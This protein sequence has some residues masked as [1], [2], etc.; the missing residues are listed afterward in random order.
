MLRL[1]PSRLAALA[2]TVPAVR[3]ASWLARR[4]LAHDSPC[5]IPVYDLT[6]AGGTYVPGRSTGTPTEGADAHAT[7]AAAVTLLAARSPRVVARLANSA[8]FVA[9]TVGSTSVAYDP[10]TRAV[11]LERA[12]VAAR[13]AEQVAVMLAIG[14]A[15]ARFHWANFRPT[16]DEGAQ[17]RRRLRIEAH[18]VLDDLG[19][20]YPTR[21]WFE[22]WIPAGARPLGA[23]DSEVRRHLAANELPGWLVRLRRFLRD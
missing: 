9:L 17:M 11:A 18:A 12:Q 23:G 21:E 1:R 19:A 14:A 16:P 10:A 20:S 8:S 7:L 5:G 13:T 3:L 22:H 2:I 6:P 4:G 15:M